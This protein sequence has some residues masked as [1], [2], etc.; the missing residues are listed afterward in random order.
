MNNITLVDG[1]HLLHRVFYT[2]V[3]KLENGVLHGFLRSLQSYSRHYPESA[4]IVLWDHGTPTFRQSICSEYKK[5]KGSDTTEVDEE[6]LHFYEEYGRSRAILNVMLAEFGMLSL[7]LDSYEADDLIYFFRHWLEAD[8]YV[9]IT[10]D[11]DLWQLIDDKTTVYK[12]IADV[13]VNKESFKDLGLNPDSPSLVE[14]YIV[15]KSMIGDH[16][17]NISG[18][19]GIG[20]VNATRIINSLLKGNF[21]V[22]K[23]VDKLYT[24]NLDIVQRNIKLIDIG[25]LVDHEWDSIL[26]GAEAVLSS[27]GKAN[28]LQV[29]KLLRKYK[30]SEVAAEMDLL[31]NQGGDVWR[32]V[33]RNNT[34]CVYNRDYS[35]LNNFSS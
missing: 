9:I 11:A 30:L 5:W 33:K 20:A 4:I 13:W 3:V 32:S 2:N 14:Q 8:S 19:K 15:R 31:I 12:P 7:L 21:E 26:R 10:E 18:V 27:V 29:H 25:Y 22:Q 16:S 23:K 17:D 6:K 35:W 1:S 24:D 28:F 34:K